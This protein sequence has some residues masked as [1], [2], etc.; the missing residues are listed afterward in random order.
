M[1]QCRNI[2][3]LL[4]CPLELQYFSKMVNHFKDCISLENGH[5]EQRASSSLSLASTVFFYVQTLVHRTAIP[6]Y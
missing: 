2:C 4:Y 1:L 3:I 6:S 5:I